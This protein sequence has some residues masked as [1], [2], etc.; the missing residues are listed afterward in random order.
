VF[1]QGNLSA[2]EDA[3][4]MPTSHPSNAPPPISHHHSSPPGSMPPPGSNA[5]ASG[6]QNAQRSGPH[7]KA[8]PGTGGG[9]G[10]AAIGVVLFLVVAAAAGAAWFTGLIPH[11]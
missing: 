8:K 4:P 9:P 7:S 1:E 5:M 2:L 6:S 10:S 3:E 11:H